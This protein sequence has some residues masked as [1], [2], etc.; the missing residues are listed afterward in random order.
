MDMPFDCSCVRL[1]L[2]ISRHHVCLLVLVFFVRS[3][4]YVHPESQ[5]WIPNPVIPNH[6]LCLTKDQH[7]SKVPYM[8]DHWLTSGERQSQLSSALMI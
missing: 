4:P 7:N 6:L 8:S 1:D 2:P 3:N 5:S